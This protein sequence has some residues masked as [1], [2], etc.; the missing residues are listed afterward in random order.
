MKKFLALVLCLTLVLTCFT[1]LLGCSGFRTYTHGDWV[2]KHIG[3]GECLIKS[4]SKEGK[5]KEVLIFPTEVAGKKVVGTTYNPGGF[6]GEG[7]ETIHAPNLKRLYFTDYVDIDCCAFYFSSAVSVFLM[8]DIKDDL[9]NFLRVYSCSYVKNTVD[10]KKINSALIANVSYYYNYENAPFEGF[11]WLDD[12]GDRRWVDDQSV[13]NDEIIK[14]PPADPTRDGYEFAGWY[15]EPE[16]INKWNF[17]TDVVPAKK[18]EPVLGPFDNLFERKR[19]YVY[20]ETALFA[21][22]EKV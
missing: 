3:N 21:K 2:I 12:Y 20:V 16:C 6:F 18:Y 14:Y 7:V 19:K 9:S 13:Q 10:Y 22:W 1:A 5:K 4:L 15:K 17:E 11:Y 8:Y